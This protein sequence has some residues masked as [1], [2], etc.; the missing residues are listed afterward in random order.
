MALDPAGKFGTMEEQALFLAR[1]FRDQGGLF[2][3][4]FLRPLDAES[5]AAYAVEGLQSEALD[6]SCF[7]LSEL[8]RLLRLVRQK[9]IDV[10]HW[11]FYHPIVNPYLWLLAILTPRVEH[12]YT[13]HISRTTQGPVPNGPLG[14]KSKLKE[15]MMRRYHKVLCVSDYILF[16]RGLAC[17]PRLQRIHHFINTERFRP[18]ASAR[19]EVR[20]AMGV[21]DEFVVVV[22]AHLIREKGVHVALKAL[23]ELPSNVLLWIIGQGP[24]EGTLQALARELGLRSRARLLGSRRFVEP[25]MQAA[26]CAVC[27]SLWAEAAGLVNLEAPACGLP[28]VASRIGGIPE[29]VEDGRNGF[30]FS[31][32][33]HHE[34][35]ER[36]ERLFHDEQSRERL[37]RQARSFV[38]EGFSTESLLAAHLRIYQTDA[39]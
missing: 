27:P 3:P 35:A 24:E 5:S 19:R 29:F 36:V 4:V 15:S 11:S 28:V 37:G 31:P 38:V 34:L 1:A 22:V 39:S 26:D 10:V 18:D 9:R 21:G 20:E 14:L 30:L 8:T 13:D 16:Q 17:G 23:A 7:R 25:F 32:G 2:L 33:D 12:Y 6:L